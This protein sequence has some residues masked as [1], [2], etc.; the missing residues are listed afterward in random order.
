MKQMSLTEANEKAKLLAYT[1]TCTSGVRNGALIAKLA[2]KILRKQHE[3][4]K[5]KYKKEKK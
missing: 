5:V 1:L 3:N 2:A 4:Q